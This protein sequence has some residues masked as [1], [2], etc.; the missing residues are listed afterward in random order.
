MTIAEKVEHLL[1]QMTLEEKAAQMDMIRGVTLATHEHPVHFCSVAEDSDFR[2]D[3]VKK[4][5]GAQGIGF[6]HDV[7]SVPGVINKLQKYLVEETRLGIPAIITGEALHGLSYPGAMSFPM[8]I[9]WGATFDP[10]L[11]EEI[12]H[13]IAHETRSLGVHEILAPNLDVARDPRWGRMEETFGEDTYLSTRMAYSIIR[14]QQGDCLDAPDRVVSEPKHY[15]AHG[16]AE[17]GL[18]CAPARC[19]EREMRSDYLPVFEA[20]VRDAGAKCA[21]AAYHSVD[22][23]PLI[24]HKYYLTDVLK[25]ELG[26]KGYIRSDFGAVPRQILI[27]HTAENAEDAIQQAVNAGLDVQG[28]DF[29]NH[30][31]QSTIVKLVKE[32]RISQERVDDA[33]R[34]ILTIKCE[35]GLFDHPY[36]D[37][38]YYQGVVRCEEHRQLGLKAA[39]EGTVLLKNDGILPLN[40][41]GKT[42]ALLGPSSS[43]QRIGSYSSTPYGYKVPSVLEELRAAVPE[44]TRILQADGCGISPMDCSPIPG[45][46]MPEG[47]SLRY[48]AKVNGDD[49]F[50]DLVAEGTSNNVAFNWMLA[51]PHPALPFNGYGVEMEGVLC[52]TED[53]D[54]TILIPCADSI[55]LWVDDDLIL[56][57]WGKNRLQNPTTPFAFRKGEKHRFR[58]AYRNDGNGGFVS[59]S[60][61]AYNQGTMDKAVEYARQ[62]D[63]A[64]LVCGDDTV[65]SGEGMD[66][67]SMTLFG[68]QKELV[69]RVAETGTPV[70][71]VLEVGKPVDLTD[72]EPAMNAILLPWFGGEMGAPAIVNILLGKSEPTGR[73]PVSFPRDVGCLPCYYSRLPGASS[74]NYLEGT[75]HPRYAFGHGLGYTTFAITDAHYDVTKENQVDLTFTVTN[76]GD[77]DGVV[78]PQVYVQDVVSSVVTPPKRLCAFQR[79]ALK[80]GESVTH[81]FTLDEK[82]FRLMNSRRQWVVEPGLFRLHLGLSSSDIHQTVEF[83]L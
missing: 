7:Y 63:V 81:T 69:R 80:K 67:S 68:A 46:W 59:L 18:N 42:I 70:V 11:V 49:S 21:M 45:E 38:T 25:G 82:A 28:F 13:A 36:T 78:I 73:L 83:R 1:S 47:V 27:H 5:V 14:G 76:T 15:L 66:R 60:Y 77:R 48:F 34:R 9:S 12:G 23:E 31:W 44:S 65:T 57:S 10:D 50:S 75:A 2:W 8:P 20:G 61:A 37:E 39:E 79:I 51:K 58:M 62:A 24:S 22:G 17:G 3:D 71:L 29:P 52:P 40:V 6:I 35:L 74:V 54:G 16:F 72:E 55:R 30:V 32:G 64:I 26:L 41:E 53:V 19:G 43:R 56:D 4:Q 33:V